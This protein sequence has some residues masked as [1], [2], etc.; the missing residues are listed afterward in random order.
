MDMELESPNKTLHATGTGAV[1]LAA[2]HSVVPSFG[3]P[4]RELLRYA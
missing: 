1:S 4:V 2:G 3:V